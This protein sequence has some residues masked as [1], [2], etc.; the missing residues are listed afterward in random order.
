MAQQLQSISSWIPNPKPQ[1]NHMVNNVTPTTHLTQKNRVQICQTQICW[2]S[3]RRVTKKTDGATIKAYTYA[4]PGI[5][6]THHMFDHKLRGC[7]CDECISHKP[8]CLQ[9]IWFKSD[10]AKLASLVSL[11]CKVL[12][13]G[14]ALD[15]ALC[16]GQCMAL[17]MVAGVSLLWFSEGKSW[18]VRG[19]RCGR[20]TRTYP[21]CVSQFWSVGQSP[22]RTQE[23]QS[24]EPWCLKND[25]GQFL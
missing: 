8:H 25:L 9:T 13:C 4:Y 14:M 3:Y 17:G 21:F 1:E 18:Y 19:H 16:S 2:G 5:F 20:R 22:S 23:R 6:H 15:M 11:W 7:H 24:P 12:K 10:P